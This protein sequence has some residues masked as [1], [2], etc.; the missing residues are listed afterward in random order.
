MIIGIAGPMTLELL[1]KELP[2]NIELPS[3]YP[4]PMTAML[5]NGLIERGYRVIAFTTSKGI[6]EPLVLHGHKLTLCIARWQP[7]AARD[8]FYSERKDLLMLMKNHQADIINAQW[9]YEFAWAAISAKVPCLITLHDHAMTIL[10]Y[11]T[12]PYRFMRLIMNYIVLKKACHLSTNSQYLFNLLSKKNKQKA[13]VIPNFYSKFLK[14]NPSTLEEKASIIL[15]VSNGFGQ[16]KNIDTALKAFAVARRSHPDIEYHLVGDGMQ[17]GGPAYRYAVANNIAE[18]V[19][20]IG[21]LSYDDVIEEM[22]KAQIFLHPS[23]EESFGMVVLEAMV[24]G[25]PVV[26]GKT[27]GNIPYLLDHGNAGVLCDVNSPKDI[28]RG[29]LKLLEKDD[30]SE[31][32]INKAKEFAKANFSEDLIVEAYLAYY[33]DIII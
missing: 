25:T 15:S 7:H 12:D 6:Q 2:E 5:V 29:V 33:R 14:R 31:R 30:L 22:N 26:G 17:V 9:S 28:A 18:G 32:L 10:R 16:R 23:R 27:S 21:K 24:I 13:R 4:F 8:L 1:K 19:C 3:G 20:F 11:Q